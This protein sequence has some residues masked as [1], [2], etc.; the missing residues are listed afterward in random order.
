[1]LKALACLIAFV[2][3]AAFGGPDL[4]F[5][6]G[7]G[8]GSARFVRRGG[9]DDDEYRAEC[10]RGRRAGWGRAVALALLYLAHT[11]R[12]A[13]RAHDAGQHAR[14]G[15]A[16]ED[17]GTGASGPCPTGWGGCA[18]AVGSAAGSSEETRG[19]DGRDGT[20]RFSRRVVLSAPPRRAAIDALSRRGASVTEAHNQHQIPSREHVREAPSVLRVLVLGFSQPQRER[21]AA[22]FPAA[23]RSAKDRSRVRPPALAGTFPPR[24]STSFRAHRGHARSFTSAS[25]FLTRLDVPEVH[26]ARRQVVAFVATRLPAEKLPL[27]ALHLRRRAPPKADFA[28]AASTQVRDAV[29]PEQPV[30]VTPRES[31][32]PRAQRVVV[33]VASQDRNDDPTTERSSATGAR[34]PL[35]RARAAS[36]PLSNRS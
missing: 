4:P 7:R 22:V 13:V 10:R 1:M 35:A 3:R 30:V 2:G 11:G 20:S 31:R 17:A 27:P 24:A 12:L 19:K 16:G 9:H 21:A 29:L 15:P 18:G 33:L 25:F 26:L 32:L 28:L 23:L 14:A 34:R 8:R 36:L 6:L 5:G